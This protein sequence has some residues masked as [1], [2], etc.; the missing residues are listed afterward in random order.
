MITIRPAQMQA[1]RQAAFKQFEDEVA[2]HRVKFNPRH[3]KA[4]GEEGVRRV[5]RL[6]FARAAEHGFTNRGPLQFYIDLMFMFGS[7]FDTDPQM[8]WAAEIL[9]DSRLTD[10][11]ERADRLYVGT[12]D[13]LD[14]VVGPRLKYFTE[15][16]RRFRRLHL[17]DLRMSP[18]DPGDILSRLENN[19]TQKYHYV[20]ERLLRQ[21]ILRGIETTKQYSVAGETGF[22]LFIW[23]MFVIGHGFASDPL[24]PWIESTLKL[25]NAAEPDR[26]IER[27]Y[28][29]VIVYLDHV[30][31]NS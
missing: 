15:S 19:H 6:G 25:R 12:N 5:I 18:E 24:Y 30:L 7:D 23:A 26:R 3:C 20:G 17:E 1:F 21:L 2:G 28:H 9:V 8:A 10:Q 22:G 13:Y 29:K 31:A 14:K 16:L 11:M 27:L 4:L